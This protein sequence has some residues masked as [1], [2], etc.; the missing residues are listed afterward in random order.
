MTRISLML[1]IFVLAI[2]SFSFAQMDPVTEYGLQQKK[3]GE[4]RV[5]EFKQQITIQKYIESQPNSTVPLAWLRNEL[6]NQKFA[7]S[8][9][10]AAEIIF[11]E[12]KNGTIITMDVQPVPLVRL[13]T[14][15]ECERLNFLTTAKYLIDDNIKM[16]ERLKQMHDQ[17]LMKI[18]KR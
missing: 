5:L 1:F 16:L 12:W 18:I 3:L 4:Q 6:I 13:P 10:E 15:A 2:P 14:I 7:K 11:R 9:D 8:N 17:E